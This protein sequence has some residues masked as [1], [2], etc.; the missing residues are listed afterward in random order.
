MKDIIDYSR[1]IS[2]YDSILDTLFDVRLIVP[3]NIPPYT[4]IL[5]CI[6]STDED[7]MLLSDESNNINLDWYKVYQSI[8][9]TRSIAHVDEN[10]SIRYV[11]Y[12]ESVD[13]GDYKYLVEDLTN[14]TLLY[15]NSIGMTRNN[16]SILICQNKYWNSKL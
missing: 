3:V 16:N 11:G 4:R 8:D 1:P 5:V 7:L 13:N 10:I 12:L 14:S 15:V 9:F 6:K 2:V